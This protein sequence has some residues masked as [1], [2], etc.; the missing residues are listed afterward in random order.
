MLTIFLILYFPSVHIV[1]FLGICV[2][3]LCVILLEVD[4][5]AG[6][7]FSLKEWAV[8]CILQKYFPVKKKSYIGFVCSLNFG[9]IL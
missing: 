2:V 3:M 5:L 9:C 1:H 4:N 6:D 8:T 7:R